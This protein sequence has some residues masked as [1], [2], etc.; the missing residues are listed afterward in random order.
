M[1]FI[2][3]LNSPWKKNTDWRLLRSGYA[4]ECIE[5]GTGKLHRE[6]LNN[7]YISTNRLRNCYG[8]H[9]KEDGNRVTYSAYVSNEDSRLHKFSTYKFQFLPHRQHSPSAL[10]RPSDIC[11]IGKLP[12]YILSIIRNTLFGKVQNFLII[13]QVGF[14]ILKILI[15]SPEG[16]RKV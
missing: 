4:G 6:K 10:D 2:R 15:R 13:Q 16:G 8:D 1:S 5:V 14:R 11:R 9:L 7:L 3:V 12:L